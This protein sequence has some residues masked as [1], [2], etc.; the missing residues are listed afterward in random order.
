MA[1][2]NRGSDARPSVAVVGAGVTGTSAA[3]GFLDAGF[4]VTLYSDRDRESL[5]DK[6]PPTGVGV[7]FGSSRDW[8]AQ[9]I[10]DLYEVGNTTGISVRLSSIPTTAMSHRPSTYDCAPTTGS[11]DSSNAA[12]TSRSRRSTPTV[13]TRSRRRA[14]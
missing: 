14:I 3:L 5:R 13:S 7:L 8:D 2:R 10:D 9:I 11:A 4:D 1:E 6:V 12:D